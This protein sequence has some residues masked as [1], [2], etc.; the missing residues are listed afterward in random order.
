MRKM[1]L[2][3]GALLVSFNCYANPVVSDVNSS[4][5]NIAS[6]LKNTSQ[7]VTLNTPSLSIIYGGEDI[8]NPVIATAKEELWK[9]DST[10]IG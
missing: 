2:L 6:A 8:S 7:Q 10:A 3:L 9:G 5:A 4:N 1:G